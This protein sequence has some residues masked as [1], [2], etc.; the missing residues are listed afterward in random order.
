MKLI[1]LLSLILLLSLTACATNLDTASL[2]TASL[3]TASLDT[4]SL[5]TAS[6]N[7]VYKLA[8]EDNIE[9]QLRL[10]DMYY[11]GIDTQRSYSDALHWYNL[12]QEYTDGQA[13]YNMGLMYSEG[14]GTEVNINKALEWF[15]RSANN[16]HN[17]STTIVRNHEYFLDISKKAENGDTDAQVDLGLIFSDGTSIYGKDY[18]KAYYWFNKAAEKNNIDAIYQLAILYLYGDGV[19]QDKELSHKLYLHAAYKGHQGAI[20]G[21]QDFYTDEP[22]AN[23]FHEVHNLYIEA[24]NGDRR[25][26]YLLAKIYYLEE[27]EDYDKALEWFNKS[28][29]QG[30][31]SAQINLAGL[32]YMGKGVAQDYQKALEWALKSANQG[33]S[34]AQYNV[35]ILYYNGQG[36]PQNYKKAYEWYSKAAKQGNPEALNNLGV[37]YANGIGITKNLVKAYANYSVSASLGD[38]SAQENIEGIRWDMTSKEINEAQALAEKM[39]KA[40][41]KK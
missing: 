22:V 29:K 17:N 6:F 11:Y 25:A 2:D 32:Y 24:K 39:W 28:A 33:N 40:L 9:A 5:D 14:R 12:A 19:K 36:T 15:K 4:A 8:H 38:E 35:A 31:S 10:A 26:Q 34:T 20:Y 30:D 1:N 41:P 21:L 23:P 18:D 13:Q 27:L 16:G 7:T 37:M 3:D